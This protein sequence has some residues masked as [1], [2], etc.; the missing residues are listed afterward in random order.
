MPN[1]ER[2]SLKIHRVE[3]EE[4]RKIALNEGES[5]SVIIRRLI[6]NEILRVKIQTTQ[7]KKTFS[8]EK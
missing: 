2:L 7:E 4:L 1:L 6:R 3:K 5:I 8:E